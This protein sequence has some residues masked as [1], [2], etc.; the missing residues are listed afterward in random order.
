MSTPE[1]G[2]CAAAV[3]GYPCHLPA[4]QRSMWCSMCRPLGSTLLFISTKHSMVMML[5]N[6]IVK[7]VQLAASVHPQ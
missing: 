1:M 4:V 7:D 6:C 5:F 3:K 2:L